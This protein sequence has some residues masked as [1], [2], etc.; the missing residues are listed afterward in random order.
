MKN[1]NKIILSIILFILIATIIYF[2]NDR[3]D[4]KL[5]SPEKYCEEDKDCITSCGSSIGKGN[6]FN[7]R[8]VK[9]NGSAIRSPLDDTCCGCD[10]VQYNH[11]ECQ[12]NQCKTIKE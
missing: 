10:Y 4:P 8:Y 1:K 7:I 9:I 12:N 2:S 3:K 5:V 6:C 11:C